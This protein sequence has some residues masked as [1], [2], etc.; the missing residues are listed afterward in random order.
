MKSHSSRKFL[1]ASLLLASLTV[2]SAYFLPHSWASR[3]P[4]TAVPLEQGTSLASQAP[5]V[6][7]PADFS[8]IV[9]KY[10]PAVVNISVTGRAPSVD[11]P[12]FESDDPLFDFFHRFG[13]QFPRPPQQ[14]QLVRGLGSGFIVQSD[15]LILT[16]AHVVDGAQEVTVK[17][18]DRRE[19]RAK[20]LGTDRQTDVAVIKI[21]EKN[22]PT[23]QL[24]NPTAVKVG[25]PVLAI[26]SPYGFENSATSG[27]VSAKSRS[28]ANDAYVPF[29]QTDVA[30]NPGNSGGPLFNLRGE[31]IGI[32][33]QIYSRTGGFQGLS[34]AIPIDVAIRTK[35]Q[36]VRT[37]K[38]SR[39]RLGIGIQDVDQGLAESFGLKRVAG[40]LVS[41][42]ERGSPAEMA[43]LK[44]GD[45]IV[46]MD[47]HDIERSA[48]LPANVAALVPGTST[49]LEIVRDGTSKTVTVK[50]AELQ[51]QLAEGKSD[52]GPNEGVIGLAV[53]PLERE[54]R[55][56][57]GVSQG[58]LVQG[59]SGNAAL[60][61][62]LPGDVIVAV[63]GAPVSKV[64]QLQRMVK[65]SGR[66]LALLIQRDEARIYIPVDVG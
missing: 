21:N 10:G 36:L 31:V 15:G 24:G 45:V 3:R 50:V 4:E 32:N 42:V 66:R 17:L 8:A 5:I 40:A 53:R 11:L 39:G 18:T 59:V 49:K 6:A 25:E 27:I 41:S 9:G 12:E 7:A 58:L 48:D 37:G 62:I 46:R 34:F 43:G 65:N 33:S 19:Y 2:G 13:P 61:G 54:E 38:V 28:L 63:N 57:V 26:G 56:S 35:D 20:V 64:E 55:Q 47:G 16:N 30:V 44:P 22:L 29:I 14:G 1:G 51:P 60:A 52:S 23:V